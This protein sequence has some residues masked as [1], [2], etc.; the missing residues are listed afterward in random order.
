M[1]TTERLLLRDWQDEDVAPFH[2][3]SQDAEVM[4][5][6]GPPTTIEQAWD[7]KRRMNE[8][9]AEL[10]YCFWALERRADRSFIGFCGLLP[11]KPPIEGEVEIGWRLARE[12]W[13][14]GYA[15]EAAAATLA[16]TW[17]STDLP[18]VAA[19]TVPANRRSW[20]LMERLDMVRVLDGDFD[21]PDLP[22]GDP[23][24]RHILYRVARPDP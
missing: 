15:R 22:D 19:I 5:Y 10:S 8:R 9:Q 14:Q 2:A 21:H 6:L 1:I 20:R 18:S 24:R 7:V 13:R 4:R 16:W 23:L 11:A 17:S 3:M 12:A